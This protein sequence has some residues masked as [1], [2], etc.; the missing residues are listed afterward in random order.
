MLSGSAEMESDATCLTE[1]FVVACEAREEARDG[2]WVL[3]EG[4]TYCPIA[5]SM[6]SVHLA[7]RSARQL[8]H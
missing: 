4:R 2:R 1:Y 6:W 5:S 3:R 7:Q 8:V